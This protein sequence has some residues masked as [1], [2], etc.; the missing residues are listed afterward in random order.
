MM[1]SSPT[2]Q[3]RAAAPLRAGSRHVVDDVGGDP[4]TGAFVTDLDEFER[5]D[6]DLSAM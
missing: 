5:V 2:W 6:A 4:C 3:V 1:I